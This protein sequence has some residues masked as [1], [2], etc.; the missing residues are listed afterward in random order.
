MKTRTIFWYFNEKLNTSLF[1]FLS[2]STSKQLKNITVFSIFYL[3]I[4]SWN[5]F[6]MWVAAAGV[7]YDISP[8]DRSECLCLWWFFTLLPK[9]KHK[10]AQPTQWLNLAPGPQVNIIKGNSVKRDS[11]FAR[12]GFIQRA[13]KQQLKTRQKK[14]IFVL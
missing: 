4:F 10:A 13:Q 12:G 2:F 1:S 7:S 6:S 8:A 5:W 9:H 11:M 14:R 3:F